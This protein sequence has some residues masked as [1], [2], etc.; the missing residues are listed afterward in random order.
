[1][2]GPAEP[3]SP[4]PALEYD[5]TPNHVTRGQFRIFLILLSIIT[6]AVVG[7]LWAPNS[8]AWTRQAWREYQAKRAATVTRQKNDAARLQRVAD[9]QKSLPTLATFTVPADELVYTEDGV[10]AASLLAS[11]TAYETVSLSRSGMPSDLWQTPVRRRADSEDVQRL[12][13]FVSSEGRNNVP[14]ALALLHLRKNPAGA[15]RLLLCAFDAKHSASGTAYNEWAIVSQ[16]ALRVRLIDPGTAERAPTTLFDS[17]TLVA[18]TADDR[19]TIKAGKEQ[20][21]QVFRVLPGVVDPVDA[22]RATVPYR[23]NGVEGTFAIRILPGD[24]LSVEPSHGRIVERTGSVVHV[25]TWLPSA[26]P[27]TRVTQPAEERKR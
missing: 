16:R 23:I 5:R 13:A 22:T 25:Q 10:E 1:M 27:A 11:D 12:L 14:M 17:E 4:P 7:Y 9:L 15:D 19:A 26:P 24:Q 2:D 6:V 18:Q 3:S 20:T 8:L 21:P